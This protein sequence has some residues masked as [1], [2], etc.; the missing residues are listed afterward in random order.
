MFGDF[1]INMHP[2]DDVDAC[3]VRIPIRVLELLKQG[4]YRVIKT[5]ED[6]LSIIDENNNEVGAF[7]SQPTI[8]GLE[9]SEKDCIY[10]KN[11]DM[12]LEPKHAVVG[13]S[14]FQIVEDGPLS[15]EFIPKK[16][17]SKKIVGSDNK[18]LAIQ[19]HTKTSFFKSQKFDAHSAEQY[20]KEVME[21]YQYH[22]RTAQEKL[23]EIEMELISHPKMDVDQQKII[24]LYN[25]YLE[26]C[27]Q[28]KADDSNLRMLQQYIDKFKPEKH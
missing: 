7:K 4:D 18:P 13:D 11:D 8:K 28:I 14:A 24:S 15:K 22:M 6:K 26:T 9:E 23:N 25:V 2:P 1:N 12:T 10:R 19:N 3:I 17:N 5:A 21:K 20:K 16:S 27:Q